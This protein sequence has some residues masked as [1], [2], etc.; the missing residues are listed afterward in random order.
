MHVARGQYA[1][2]LACMRTAHMDRS[3]LQIEQTR[4][5]CRLSALERK[6][7]QRRTARLE[8]L[9]HTQRLAVVGRLMADIYHALDAPIAL[10]HQALARCIEP[11][12]PAALTAALGQVIEQIDAVTALARQLKMFSYRAAPQAMVVGLHESLQEAWTGVALWRR[13]SARRLCVSGDLGTQVQVDV[14]RLAVLLRILLIEIDKAEPTE[15]LAARIARGERCSRME[16]GGPAA[17]ARATTTDPSVGVTL[18]Q[19]IVQEMGGW[20]TRSVA[21]SGA[22]G[23]V[24]E[25]PAP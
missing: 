15:A 14:Q 24:L 1:Q 19:E 13:G 4:L 12:P 23:F 8:T 3:R 6:A 22:S 17:D 25:L 2:A 9:M 5:R 21:A 16:L 7:V 10:T 18:C 20:L 11:V